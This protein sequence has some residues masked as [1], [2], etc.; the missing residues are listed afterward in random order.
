MNHIHQ[1]YGYLA[2]PHTAVGY[3]LAD[4]FQE[5]GVPMVALATAHPAKFEAAVTQALPKV[6]NTHSALAG[7]DRL[8]T[9]KTAMVSDPEAI[10]AFIRASC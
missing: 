10:K 2:D 3:L 4:R 6:V 1:Q 5:P 8:E 9:R 7:L